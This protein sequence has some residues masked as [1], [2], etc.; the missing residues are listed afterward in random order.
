MGV[1][2]L[3]FA[4]QVLKVIL[5]DLSCEQ[6]FN[7]GDNSSTLR[8]AQRRALDTNG[9]AVVTQPTQQGFSHRPIP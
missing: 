3:E 4:A 9:V 2:K 7:D 8:L 1:E 5:T 6:L